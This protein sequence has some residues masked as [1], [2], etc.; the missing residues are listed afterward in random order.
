[1]L[2]R[3]RRNTSEPGPHAA[4]AVACGARRPPQPAPA[5]RSPLPPRWACPARAWV[6]SC[7]APPGTAAPTGTGSPPT[8]AGRTAP[9]RRLAAGATLC[10]PMNESCTTSSAVGTSR[11]SRTARRSS[12]SKCVVYIAVAAR[13]VSHSAAADPCLACHSALATSSRRRR[14]RET[15]PRGHGVTRRG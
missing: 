10:M 3:D 1:V 15:R 2:Q 13:A 12:D 14:R 7:P 9:F 5:P 8:A 11:T 6:C 4:L